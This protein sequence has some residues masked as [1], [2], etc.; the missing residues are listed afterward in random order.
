M[1][2]KLKSHPITKWLNKN[3]WS[4]HKLQ[5]DTLEEAIKGYDILLV[6]PTGGGKTLAGFMP[7]ITDLIEK[8]YKDNFLH[9]LYISPLKALTVDVQ[10]NLV[11]PINDQSL[12]ISVDNS[13]NI[14]T[15]TIVQ[16]ID[17]DWLMQKIII[18]TAINNS[19]KAL[20]AC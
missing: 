9:T 20:I 11:Q 18:R 19:I 10:R 5:I 6:A 15:A 4:Y 16:K 17:G 2:P 13:N 8:K 12:N 3:G 7:A 1:I 14:E